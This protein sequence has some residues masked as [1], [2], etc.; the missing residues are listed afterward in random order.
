MKPKNL[1]VRLANF[2][3]QFVV[4]ILTDGIRR[5]VGPDVAD[6]VVGVW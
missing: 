5:V 2:E 4:S 3:K 1:V 6:N